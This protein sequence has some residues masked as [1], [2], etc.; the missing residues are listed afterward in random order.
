[1]QTSEE[2]GMGEEG[3]TSRREKVEMPKEGGAEV[4]SSAKVKATH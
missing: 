1:V 4:R 2:C 3:K